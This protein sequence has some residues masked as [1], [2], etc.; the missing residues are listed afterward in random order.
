MDTR[1]GYIGGLVAFIMPFCPVNSWIKYSLSFV[2]V[3]CFAIAWFYHGRTSLK[4][5]KK[6]KTQTTPSPT[7]IKLSK[8]AVKIL[9][10]VADYGE[11][12][13][14]Y[15]MGITLIESLVKIEYWLQYLEDIN[16][17]SCRAYYTDDE[18]E[19]FL[20]QKGR[21]YLTHNNMA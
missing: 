1:L 12:T 18:S 15:I 7:R 6:I 9:K 19:Y 8:E 16:F 11:P 21:E 4:N 5:K 14:G 2:G 17:I 10:A 3:I 20:K 13:A